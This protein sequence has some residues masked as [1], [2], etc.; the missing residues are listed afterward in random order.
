MEPQSILPATW[1]VPEI[2]RRRM[3]TSVGRQRVLLSDGHMLL[4]LHA[5]P[6]PDEDEREGR[7]FWRSPDGQWKSTEQGNGLQSLVEHLD[8]YDATVE[9]YDRQDEQASDSED[10]FGVLDGL[11]PVHRAAQNLHQV[12]Q[13]ARQSCP[14]DR[15]ILNL[16]DRAYKIQR[17]AE[18]LYGSAKNALDFE[19]ARRAEQQA[20]AGHKMAVSAHKLNLM[21]SFFFPVATL[22]AIFGVNLKF[23]LEDVPPYTPFLIFLIAGVASGG[24][25]T[26]FV[27]RSR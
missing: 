12:L 22:S 14:E 6:K 17:T 18:L 7:F 25:L 1:D 23:G 15:D 3:G 11:A 21:A 16:R 8:D 10:Y 13:E 4:V 24:L 5:P 26:L 20:Q 19:V 2:F 9:A 27:T